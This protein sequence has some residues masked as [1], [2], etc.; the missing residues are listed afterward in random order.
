LRNSNLNL[1]DIMNTLDVMFA[2]K[3][4][5]HMKTNKLEDM[6][7][8]QENFSLGVMDIISPNSERAR[9]EANKLDL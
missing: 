9:V 6:R 3:P 4:V 7:I 8:Y 2:L 5:T 1:T